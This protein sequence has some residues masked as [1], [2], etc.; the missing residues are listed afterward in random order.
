MSQERKKDPISEEFY[1]YIRKCGSSG[2][3][4]MSKKWVG[5]R[6]KVIVKEDNE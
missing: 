5:K 2:H 4:Q 3:I 1:C 6:V